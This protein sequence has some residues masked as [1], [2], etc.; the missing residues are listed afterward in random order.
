MMHLFLV[1]FCTLRNNTEQ[2][3]LLSIILQLVSLH[4]KLEHGES[5]KETSTCVND[6]L[7]NIA[8]V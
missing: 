7:G 6:A 5:F 8:P 2:L 3:C 4:Y 1:F